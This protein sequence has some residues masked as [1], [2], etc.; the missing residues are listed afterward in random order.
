VR[1]V[2]FRV[3]EAEYQ[4]LRD[5][6]VTQGARCVSDFARQATLC[7][8][9]RSIGETEAESAA[10]APHDLIR[11]ISELATSMTRLA[12]RISGLMSGSER[13]GK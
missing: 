11:G 3:T 4:Q 5:A 10:Q 1:L 9:Q 6:C 7:R 8:T 2:N 13:Q 12:E